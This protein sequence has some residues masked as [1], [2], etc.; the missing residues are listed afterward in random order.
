[1]H[2]QGQVCPISTFCLFFPLTKNTKKFRKRHKILLMKEDLSFAGY[3]I[4][5][6]RGA[7]YEFLY[8]WHYFC[9]L[10]T[11]IARPLKMTPREGHLRFGSQM[12]RQI[13]IWNKQRFSMSSVTHSTMDYQ[14]TALEVRFKPRNPLTKGV[15]GWNYARSYLKP[16]NKTNRHA[17][18]C[19]K[20]K[21]RKLITQRSSNVKMTWRVTQD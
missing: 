18:K 21:A 8:F 19:E 12:Y 10:F 1:M 14:A 15:P 16:P 2:T 17:N 6:I 20:K 3:N 11:Q 9:V 5:I 4:S 7:S 13:C